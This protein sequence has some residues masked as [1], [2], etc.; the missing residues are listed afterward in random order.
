MINRCPVYV[1]ISG[2]KKHGKNFFTD[3]VKELLYRERISYI[4]TAFATPIKNFCHDVF[5]IPMEDMETQEG[6]LKDTHLRWSDISSNIS[7]ALEKGN[8]KQSKVDYEHMHWIPSDEFITIRELLQ[9]IGTD[10]FREGFYG[11]IWAKAPFLKQHTLVAKDANGHQFPQK[12]TPDVVFITD[13]RFPNEVDEALKH[14]ALIVRVKR[15]DL[16][17]ADDPHISETALDDYCWNPEE[18]VVAS[19]D[20]GR[21]DKFAKEVLL[22]RIKGRLYGH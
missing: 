10:V 11:P 21:L 2:K 16:K 18:L 4:E 9:I 3:K 7:E 19:T 17:E 8:Y 14:G 22:P 12:I 20:D 15:D 13:C 6:K 5:G 1:V